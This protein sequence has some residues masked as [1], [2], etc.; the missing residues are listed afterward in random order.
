MEYLNGCSTAIRHVV[1]K[2]AAMEGG[3]IFFGGDF[4]MGM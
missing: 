1:R 2:V 4:T 3:L